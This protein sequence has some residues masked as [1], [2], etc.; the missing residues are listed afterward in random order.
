MELAKKA[1]MLGA[2]A[3]WGYRTS[4]ELKKGG[5]S[6]LLNAPMDALALFA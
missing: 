1:G 6:I 4:A 2:G 3:L 5:A